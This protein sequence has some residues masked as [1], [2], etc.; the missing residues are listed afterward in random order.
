ML[1]LRCEYDFSRDAVRSVRVL[2][3]SMPGV[4]PS[5]HPIGIAR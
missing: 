2:R 4:V 1:E 3:G 5:H